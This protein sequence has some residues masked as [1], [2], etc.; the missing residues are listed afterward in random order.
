[1]ISG[2]E[3]KIEK[4]RIVSECASELF[5]T[6]LDQL[7]SKDYFIDIWCSLARKA[8]KNTR[9]VESLSSIRK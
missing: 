2:S 1:M 8:K 4:E 7:S 9:H 6:V 5:D 3:K